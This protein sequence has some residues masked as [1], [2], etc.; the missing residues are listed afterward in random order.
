MESGMNPD[1]TVPTLTQWEGTGIIIFLDAFLLALNCVQMG[2]AYL[3]TFRAAQRSID[4]LDD[5][6]VLLDA[7]IAR[8]GM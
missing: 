4:A 7:R 2:G 1:D 6:H 8:G 5:L 3:A